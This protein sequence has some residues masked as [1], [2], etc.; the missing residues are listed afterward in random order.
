MKDSTTTL[1]VNLVRFLLGKKFH[2]LSGT[3]LKQK[4]GWHQGTTMLH[5]RDALLPLIPHIIA[6]KQAS[7]S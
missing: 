7:S 5:I 6:P 1:H 3:K 2:E 4:R